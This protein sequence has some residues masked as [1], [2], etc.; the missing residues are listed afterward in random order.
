MRKVVWCLIAPLAL[1]IGTV[2][3]AGVDQTVHNFSSS[4]YSPNAFF[5][6]GNFC[7]VLGAT[8]TT[9]GCL[10]LQEMFDVDSALGLIESPS[11]RR[12]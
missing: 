7:M 9:G 12:R 3:R 1:G 8:L 2:V 5:W 4:A 6:S 10:V 11:R